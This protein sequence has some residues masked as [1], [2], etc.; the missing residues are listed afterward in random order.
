MNKTPQILF[1]VFIAS[2][3]VSCDESKGAAFVYGHIEI[4]PPGAIADF[5]GKLE[6]SDNSPVYGKCTMDGNKF[7]FTVGHASTGELS[8]LGVDAPTFLSISGI[9]GPPSKGVYDLTQTP[10]SPIDN[11]TTYK[12]LGAGVKI[13]AQTKEDKWTFAGN[14]ADCD[15]ELFAIPKDGEVI[16]EE[17]LDLNKTFDYYVRLYCSSVIASKEISTIKGRRFNFFNAELYFENC[18]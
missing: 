16:F 10:P 7:I 17:N 3:V 12:K 9:P 14:E 5:E 15:L 8:N 6:A 11:P 2:L 4:D 1:L 13:W 18:N